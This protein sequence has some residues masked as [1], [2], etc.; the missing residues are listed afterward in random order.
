MQIVIA[1][2]RE[3]KTSRYAGRLLVGQALPGEEL[4]LLDVSEMQLMC[5]KRF[6]NQVKYKE[7][8]KSI[9]IK[10]PD[11]HVEDYEQ[12]IMNN[13]NDQGAEKMQIRKTTGLR[14]TRDIQFLSFSKRQ[15]DETDPD[16]S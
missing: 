11:K 7:R 3:K 13:T 4:I 5:A 2:N 14:T 1:Y 9:V 10:D 15:R 12:I 16:N 6:P 8:T